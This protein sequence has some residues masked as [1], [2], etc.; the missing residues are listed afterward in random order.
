MS[1]TKRRA[2]IATTI[3]LAVAAAYPAPA[4]ATH[5]LDPHWAKGTSSRANLYLVDS[6]GPEWP[7]G[8]AINSW[9]SGLV[10]KGARVY[11]YYRTVC[12]GD[13]FHCIKVREYVNS[14]APNSGCVDRYGCTAIAAPNVF[15]HHTRVNVWFN[16]TYDF[17]TS[18]RY[19]Q[20][21]CHEIGHTFTLDERTATTTCMNQDLEI[22]T[23]SDH[24]F[25]AVFNIYDH[26]Q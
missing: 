22:T 3:S 4:S 9:N 21:A 17:Y 13:E 20:T 19:R 16:V 12:P 7:V 18:A 23:P 25:E 11:L 14:T 10:A 6:T 26:S 8:S 5:A 24:D 15:D 2:A 1:S